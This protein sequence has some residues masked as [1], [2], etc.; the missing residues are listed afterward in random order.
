[1]KARRLKKTDLY[2]D[3]GDMFRKSIALS[4]GGDFGWLAEWF[5]S[6]SNVNLA[7]LVEVMNGPE[8][9]EFDASLCLNPLLITDELVLSLVRNVPSLRRLKLNHT[10]I[11]DTALLAVAKHLPELVELQVSGPHS[12][13]APST[14]RIAPSLFSQHLHGSFPCR[15]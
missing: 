5:N 11:T 3:A 13:F 1:M 4:P 8:K 12:L 9:V 6:L 7:I 14:H 10:A 2:E 15:G